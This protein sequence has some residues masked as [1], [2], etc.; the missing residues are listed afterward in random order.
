VTTD[1]FVSFWENLDSRLKD[2]S[3]TPTI[4]ACLPPY[5]TT[6]APRILCVDENLDPFGIGGLKQVILGRRHVVQ[7]LINHHKNAKPLRLP[8]VATFDSAFDLTK[9]FENLASL[10]PISQGKQKKMRDYF[11]QLL[12]T[13][14]KGNPGLVHS[15][16]RSNE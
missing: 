9:G 2:F 16:M 10:Q 5:L 13:R 1:Y 11:T 6:V 7:T 15:T 12:V 4:A 3:E 8:V 14:N